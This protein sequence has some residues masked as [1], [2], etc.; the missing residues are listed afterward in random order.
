MK[1]TR[2]LLFVLAV[3]AAC[4]LLFAA[5]ALADDPVQPAFDSNS[6]TLNKSVDLFN[7]VDGNYYGPDITFTYTVAPATGTLPP[8]VDENNNTIA[9]RKPGPADA[10]TYPGSIVYTSGVKPFSANGTPDTTTAQLSF[11]MTK[12]TA[13]GVYRYVVTDTTTDAALNA[14]GIVRPQGYDSEL[15][16]D[17][18]VQEGENG[19]EIYGA[20]LIRNDG[21]TETKTDGFD[22]DEYHTFNV[23]V[24]KATEGDKSHEFPFS[25]AVSNNPGGDPAA[26]MHYYAGKDANALTDVT[27]ASNST[28]LKDGDTYYIYGLNPKATVNV[29]ETNDTSETYKVTVTSPTDPVHTWVSETAVAPNGTVTMSANDEAVT[30]YPASGAPA[31]VAQTD[32]KQIDFNNKYDAVSPTGLALRYGPFVLLL[33]GAVC[34]FIVGRKRKETKEESD[35]I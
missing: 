27:A 12:F 7:D 26:N 9:Q 25:V 16:L 34:F 10:V 32:V 24:T 2:K 22:D 35:S 3:F 5:T 17:V 8:I 13:P 6:I 33:A 29:T 31:S 18:Y 20:I 21:E 19:F 30:N 15:Y 4:A 11:D 1:K 28:T 23:I 14:A